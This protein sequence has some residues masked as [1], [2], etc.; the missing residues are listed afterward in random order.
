MQGPD[1]F[2]ILAA[3]LP[4]VP[5]TLLLTGLGLGFGFLLGLVLAFLRVYSKDLAPIA[6]GYEKV[7][8]GIP[9]LVVIYIFYFGFPQLFGFLPDLMRPFFSV[10][11]SLGIASAAFQSQIFRGAILSVSPG[12]VMAA[13]A[14]GMTN[15]QAQLHIVL[16]QALRLALPGWTNEYALVI[17]DASFASAIGLADMVRLARNFSATN[18]AFMFP[19]LLMVAVIYFILT[20]PVTNFLGERQMRKLRRIGIGGK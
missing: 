10:S 8:R 1:I 12:Q 18:P 9:V 5:V 15:Y 7:M 14:I 4:G 17:K 20:Y 13:R 19:A 3:V 11:F 6:E 2:D 16:P